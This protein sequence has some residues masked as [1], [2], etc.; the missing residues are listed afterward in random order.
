VCCDVTPGARRIP[1]TTTNLTAEFNAEKCHC[2]LLPLQ[3]VKRSPTLL[4]SICELELVATR[5]AFDVELAW[6][7]YEYAQSLSYWIKNVTSLDRGYE[8]FED[9]YYRSTCPDGVASL[10][11]MSASD[12]S[13]MNQIKVQHVALPVLVYVV[14]TSLA[15]FLSAFDRGDPSESED[16]ST[17]GK[18]GKLTRCVTLFGMY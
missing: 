3:F 17:K 14:C 15:M 12:V 18:R 10:L 11:A 4:S 5:S 1:W 2:L 6:P 13:E 8:V 16:T 7:A 9:D